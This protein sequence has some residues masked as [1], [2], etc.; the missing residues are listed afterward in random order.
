MELNDP[1]HE[2][3]NMQHRNTT[4]AWT[5][6]MKK[7]SDKTSKTPITKSIEIDILG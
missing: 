5:G 2:I 1:I 6:G 4:N 3:V 7:N